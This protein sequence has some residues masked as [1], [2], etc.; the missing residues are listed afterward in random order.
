MEVIVPFYVIHHPVVIA[1]AFSVV[2]WDMNLYAKA[3]TVLVAS[4][5]LTMAIIEVA[6]RRFSWMRLLFGMPPKRLPAAP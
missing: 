3:L 5:V 4:F 6:I 1:V 2:Q